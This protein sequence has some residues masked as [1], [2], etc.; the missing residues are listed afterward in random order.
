MKILL[1]VVMCL[2]SWQASAV[3][4]C[5]IDGKTIYLQGLCPEG[6]SRPIIGGKFSGFST[7]EIRQEIAVDNNQIKA[8]NVHNSAVKAE[9][10]S[11]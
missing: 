8:K 5:V 10:S 11:K 3:Q 9:T 1:I 2:L 6:T 4:K 7:S